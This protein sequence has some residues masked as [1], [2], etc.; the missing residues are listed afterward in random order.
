MGLFVLKLRWL[1]GAKNAF[2]VD[3]ALCRALH[4]LSAEFK[5]TKLIKSEQHAQEAQVEHKATLEAGTGDEIVSE[6]KE[7]HRQQLSHLGNVVTSSNC[8]PRSVH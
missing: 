3:R 7:W 6:S 4:D 8:Q 2:S 1:P 5:Y